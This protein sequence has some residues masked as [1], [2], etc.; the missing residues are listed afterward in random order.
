[1]QIQQWEL[2][3]AAAAL[4]R[5]MLDLADVYRRTGN[6][7]E[8]G[9]APELVSVLTDVRCGVAPTDFFQFQ[10]TQ[11]GGV[12]TDVTYYAMAFPRSTA[13]K[14]GDIVDI[15]TQGVKI[16]V[17]QVERA[18]SL[19]TMLH[20]YGQGIDDTGWFELNLHAGGHS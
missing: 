14:V 5:T 2:D 13:I 20:V 7:S 15:F 1:M 9:G 10:Q 8:Y 16:T 3:R 19:D 17:L 18:E 12:Q 6:E 4:E 11:M